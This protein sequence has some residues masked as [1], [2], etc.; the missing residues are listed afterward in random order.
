[1]TIWNL[2]CYHQ[3]LKFCRFSGRVQGQ[4]SSP[5]LLTSTIR[6][7]PKVIP[8]IRWPESS[9]SQVIGLQEPKEPFQS[10]ARQKKLSDCRCCSLTLGADWQ[11]VARC[12]SGVSIG[13]YHGGE[14]PRESS[15]T[16]EGQKAAG[17]DRGQE[18]HRQAARGGQQAWGDHLSAPQHDFAWGPCPLPAGRRVLSSKSRPGLLIHDVDLLFHLRASHLVRKGTVDGWTWN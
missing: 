17:G 15:S 11:W 6:R 7:D 12:W 14:S 4:Q 5:A 8:A 10:A 2:R 13:G 9:V 18:H 1:M 16:T 3:Q